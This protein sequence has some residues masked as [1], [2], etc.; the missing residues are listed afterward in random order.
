VSRV[1]V[2]S[3]SAKQMSVAGAVFLGVG[4][5]VGAGVFALLGEAGS[6]AGSAVW[7]S[8]LFGGIVAGL[9]GYTVAKLSVRYPSKGGLVSFLQR[10][11]GD[12][13][14]SGTTSWLYYMAGLI[15]TALVALSFGSYARSLFL[16][17]DASTAWV[18]VFAA[19]AVISMAF[20][21]MVGPD[22]VGRLQSV[23]VV[24]LLIVFGVFI[25]ATLSD[26]DF[27]QLAVSTYPS[28]GQII[29]AVALT[30]FAYLG[31]AVIATTAEA[32]P[33]PGR[34]VPLATYIALTIATVL[35]VLISVGVYGTLTVEEVIASGD[36]ALAEAA[37]PTLGQAGFTMMA[38]A[39][40]LATAS[41]VNANLF[42]AGNMTASLAQAGQFPPVFGGRARFL[43][44]RGLAISVGVVLVMAMFLDLSTV[45]SV[46]SAVAL[47]VFAMVGVA[48]IRLRSDTGSNLLLLLA[49]V[50]TTLVVLVLF[51][52]D[53]ARNEPRT[54]V[55][56]LA[57]GVVAA[58]LDLLWKRQRG[59]PA[60][61][62]MP[63]ADAA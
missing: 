58:L 31:F 49:A 3:V 48:A 26:A 62:A 46:G 59:R 53:T 32:I 56:M 55:A 50:V 18:K 57:V 25:V 37:E 15:V 5:M 47:A 6:L 1:S 44:T 61:P 52:I 51:A 45:A 9:L 28:A 38:I 29:A 41:S 42:A 13:H 12:N 7:L 23:I 60:S 14:V 24:V 21:Y 17:D 54:F 30:F 2:E 22:V 11:F 43:G 10:G 19:V 35:Y 16:P 4:A 20:V 39:A 8:F 34:N 36:T 40:L 27:D 63:G 33:R